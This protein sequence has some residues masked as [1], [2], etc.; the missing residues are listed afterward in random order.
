MEQSTK[1]CELLIAHYKAYPNLQI[2]DVFKFLHQSALGCEH[3][4]SS[5][6]KATGFI[7]EEYNGLQNK[8]T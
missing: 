7:A 6:E 3:L 4:V 2:Q 8:E 5:L 1:T